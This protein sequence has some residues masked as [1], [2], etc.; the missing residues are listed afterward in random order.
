MNYETIFAWIEKNSDHP[1]SILLRIVAFSERPLTKELLVY[2]AAK[3][4]RLMIGSWN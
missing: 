1:T 2:I 3:N 4:K